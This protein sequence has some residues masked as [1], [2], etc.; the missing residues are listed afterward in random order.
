MKQPKHPEGTKMH[1]SRH[2]T[3]A[4]SL[5]VPPSCPQWD[6][7]ENGKNKSKKA[8]G[9]SSSISLGQLCLPN[10]FCTPNLWGGGSW[11]KRESRDCVQALLSSSQKIVW[12]QHC[13]SPKFRTQH[14]MIRCE[15]KLTPSPSALTSTL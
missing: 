6:R 9:L 3:A 15:E 11:K 7:G 2:C 4:C 12:Y 13:F 5:P 10:F 1:C 8:H 14:L